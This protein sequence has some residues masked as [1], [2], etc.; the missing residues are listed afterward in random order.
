MDAFDLLKRLD[1]MI[2]KRN[3]FHAKSTL[4]IIINRVIDE[5]NRNIIDES[6]VQKTQ[7]TLNKYMNKIH[8]LEGKHKVKGSS[9]QLY[10]NKNVKCL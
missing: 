5:H 6:E 3:I 10:N 2:E 7:E 9:V 1:I 4:D 8:E